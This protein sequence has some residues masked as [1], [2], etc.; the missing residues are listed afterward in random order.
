MQ[1][2]STLMKSEHC[3]P[4]HSSENSSYPSQP[5][6]DREWKI[7]PHHRDEIKHTAKDYPLN[8]QDFKVLNPFLAGN[9]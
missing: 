7:T 3:H 1:N 4:Y 2:A 5:V 9:A 6:V 8:K